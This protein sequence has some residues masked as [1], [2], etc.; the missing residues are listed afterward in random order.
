MNFLTIFCLD[1]YVGEKKCV[2]GLGLFFDEDELL[3]ELLSDV[4]DEILL[5]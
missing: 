3:I 2:E 4:V 5:L 1:V